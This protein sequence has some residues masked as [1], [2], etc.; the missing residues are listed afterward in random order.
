MLFQSKMLC[1]VFLHTRKLEHLSSLQPS[2]SIRRFIYLLNNINNH[3]PFFH[4]LSV[5]TGSSMQLCP[6]WDYIPH[7]LLRHPL[8]FPSLFLISPNQK[9]ILAI[10]T[11]LREYF[12]FGMNMLESLV[13]SRG[14]QYVFFNILKKFLRKKIEN[15]EMK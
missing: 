13:K 9:V 5:H 10:V 4:S 2:D 14:T 15:S 12:Y 1:C 6:L 11:I 3:R 7:L 8:G